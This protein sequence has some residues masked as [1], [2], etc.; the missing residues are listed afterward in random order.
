MIP[1]ENSTLC[2]PYIYI[3]DNIKKKD[4]KIKKWFT[5]KFDYD[6]TIFEPTPEYISVLSKL[7]TGECLEIISIKQVELDATELRKRALDIVKDID[8]SVYELRTVYK[9]KIIPDN[10]FKELQQR[11]EFSDIEKEIINKVISKY[12][13]IYKENISSI[14]LEISKS[15]ERSLTENQLTII[16]KRLLLKIKETEDNYVKNL[17][18][19]FSSHITT[20]IPQPDKLNLSEEQKEGI[21]S[22]LKTNLKI[23]FN[24]IPLEIKTILSLNRAYKFTLAQKDELIEILKQYIYIVDNLKLKIPVVV[25]QSQPVSKIPQPKKQQQIALAIQEQKNEQ[26]ND[27]L[28]SKKKTEKKNQERRDKGNYSEYLKYLKYKAKYLALKKQ[29]NI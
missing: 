18:E 10:E 8:F 11:L 1:P 5:K 21:H 6:K 9:K 28:L 12:D 23:T 2:S 26:R 17:N 24:Q 15:I 13:K 3:H 25:V 7:K 22:F 29:L 27:K 16:Y 4:K 19:L 14:K 20:Q